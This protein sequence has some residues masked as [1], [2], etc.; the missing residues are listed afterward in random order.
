MRG[1][2]TD[3]GVPGVKG[4]GGSVEQKQGRATAG[5]P[6]VNLH[7]PEVREGRIVVGVTLPEFRPGAVGFKGEP[8]GNRSRKAGCGRQVLEGEVGQGKVPVIVLVGPRGRGALDLKTH[9]EGP[10]NCCA[11]PARSRRGD[12]RC[13]R[14]LRRIR[15]RP[16]SSRRRIL[17]HPPCRFP[18]TPCWCPW[19]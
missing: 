13:P 6:V 17:L 16:V 3:P 2:V 18:R 19:L 10:V 4:R 15:R 9:P 1:K 12:W 5:N 11:L 7:A 14:R 8:E